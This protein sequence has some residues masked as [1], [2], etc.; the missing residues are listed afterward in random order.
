MTSSSLL[1]PRGRVT[2]AALVIALLAACGSGDDN[3]CPVS[4][5]NCVNTP[6]VVSAAI[7]RWTP[8]RAAPING[9]SGEIAG[10]WG[11]SA[12]DVFAAT[13]S[14]DIARYDGTAWTIL[15]TNAG[16]LQG[17]HGSSATDVWAVNSEG[18]IWHY[19]GTTWT[20]DIPPRRVPLIGVYA[21]NASNVFVVGDGGSA[22]RYDG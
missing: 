21:L 1:H 16:S 6:P 18:E 20:S 7:A 5:P 8:A 3:S 2:I 12:S 17:I 11:S 9:P 15:K 10:I 13:L 19:N 14:G 22:F 4:S